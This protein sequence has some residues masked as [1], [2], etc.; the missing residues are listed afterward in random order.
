M[1]DPFSFV[2]GG[3]LSKRAS[4][5]A[6]QLREPSTDGVRARNLTDDCTWSGPRESIAS[7]R[8]VHG[9]RLA[10]NERG[11]TKAC[12]RVHVPYFVLS[13]AEHAERWNI[14]WHHPRFSLRSV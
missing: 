3:D 12:R 1:G 9:A 5:S 8:H 6:D 10:P 2:V 13:G 7:L 11:D 14:C 4:Q